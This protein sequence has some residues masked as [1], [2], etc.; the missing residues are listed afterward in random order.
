M[1]GIKAIHQLI[2]IPNG[3]GLQNII[4]LCGGHG[5]VLGDWLIDRGADAKRFARTCSQHEYQ[6]DCPPALPTAAD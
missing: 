1:V 4:G 6:Q 5:L 3:T 2:T